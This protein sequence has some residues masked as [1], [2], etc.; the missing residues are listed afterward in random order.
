METR[1]E[2][3]QAL[4]DFRQI[5]RIGI[6]NFGSVHLVQNIHDNNLYAMKVLP[7]HSVVKRNQIR[8][9]M[10]EL[11]TMATIR[12]HPFMIHLFASFKDANNLYLCMEYAEGELFTLLRQVGRFDVPT[13]TIYSAEIVLC[14]EHLHGLGYAYRDLKPENVLLTRSGHI[15]L[16]DFGFCKLV[17]PTD[18]TWTLCGTPE[19]MAPEV[20][21][22]KGHDKAV[23]FWSLGVFIFE[24]L[25]GYPP[26]FGSDTIAIYENILD[27]IYFF[28]S[29]FHLPAKDLITSLLHRA[30]SKRLGN[31]VGGIKDLHN[32]H[33]FNSINWAS[34]LSGKTRA[35]PLPCPKDPDLGFFEKV[36]PQEYVIQNDITPENQRY[37]HFFKGWDDIVPQVLKP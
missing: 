33:F 1:P 36:V 14:L 23:D 26:F 25:A 13:A 5:R 4:T 28:P 24:L 11:Q 17:G 37:A 32:H 19:Y 16:C 27:G 2:Y 3:F 31:L 22:G 34:L 12:N 30:R 35:P 21:L 15:K 7:K 6:G 8:H 9:T 10:D 18:K 20:I 29:G